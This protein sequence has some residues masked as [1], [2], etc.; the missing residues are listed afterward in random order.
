LG[1]VIVGRGWRNLAEVAEV[2]EVAEEMRMRVVGTAVLSG[3]VG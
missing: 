3:A 2:A 1:R